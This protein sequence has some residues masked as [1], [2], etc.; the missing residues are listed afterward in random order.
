[1]AAR[2]RLYRHAPNTGLRAKSWAG[3][4]ATGAVCALR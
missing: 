3:G 4:D 1:M 2:M